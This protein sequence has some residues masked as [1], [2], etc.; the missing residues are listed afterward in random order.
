MLIYLL[1]LVALALII[2]PVVYSLSKNATVDKAKRAFKI[3]LC[4]FAGVML[5]AIVLPFGIQVNADTEIPEGETQ[6]VVSETAP[7]SEGMSSDGLGYLAAAL[8]TGLG[9]I[10]C[11]I[12]VASAAPAAIGAVSEEPKAFSKALIF[13]ALGEGVALYGF[14]ISFMILGKL[15]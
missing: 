6:V 13:V 2:S 1:P 7:V 14:L 10:G 5:L 15:G 12:A 11:G 9:S 3:N 8:A 4:T